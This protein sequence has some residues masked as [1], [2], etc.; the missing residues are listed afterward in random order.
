MREIADRSESQRPRT[1]AIRTREEGDTPVVITGK[2][3]LFDSSVIALIGPVSTHSYICI[4]FVKERGLSTDPI[5][6][7]VVANLFGQSEKV[8]KVCRRCPLKIHDYGFPADL[9]ALTFY[10]FDVILDTRETDSEI[11][12]ILVVRDFIDVFPKEFPCL[13]PEREVEFGIELIPGTTPIFIAPYQM[14]PTEL[15]EL[16]TQL[17]E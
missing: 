11:E 6:Y 15:K 1:Y 3:S 2:F 14:A 5:E 10:E 12:K 16:K 4:T 13:P 8:N 7:E 17:Q 9:I